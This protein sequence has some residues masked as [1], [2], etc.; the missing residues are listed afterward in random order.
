M[1]MTRYYDRLDRLII[2]IDDESIS[3]CLL[4]ADISFFDYSDLVA[5]DAVDYSWFSYSL[6]L[7]A[8]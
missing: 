4:L 6:G 7:P 1:D 8:A 2:V 5:R 3:L